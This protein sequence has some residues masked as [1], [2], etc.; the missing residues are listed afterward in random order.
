MI[1]WYYLVTSRL[2]PFKYKKFWED[3]IMNLP[4]NGRREWNK[5]TQNMLFNKVLGENEKCVFHFYLKTEGTFWPTDRNTHL[6][7]R[8]SSEKYSYLLQGPAARAACELKS[9][10]WDFLESYCFP[11]KEPFGAFCPFLLSEI[12]P[13]SLEV[14]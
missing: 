10:V 6:K 14:E 3:R 4:K 2:L 1:A 12:Q 13:W 5:P 9:A 7:W 11:G 8:L